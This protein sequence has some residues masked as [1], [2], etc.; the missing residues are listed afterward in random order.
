MF[1]L[2]FNNLPNIF[3]N[4]ARLKELTDEITDIGQ[5]SGILNPTVG[6]GSG[7]MFVM[8]RYMSETNNGAICE[9]TLYILQ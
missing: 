7:L 4:I 5:V 1:S 3:G 9:I 8:L 6:I 2:Y